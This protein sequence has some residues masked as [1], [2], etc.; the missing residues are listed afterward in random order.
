MSTSF[1]YEWRVAAVWAHYT[2]EQFEELDGSRQATIIALYETE[3]QTEA[4][5]SEAAMKGGG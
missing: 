5:L 1:E 4:V 2:Q 3:R